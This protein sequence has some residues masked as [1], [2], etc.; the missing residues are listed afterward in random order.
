[1]DRV[2]AIPSRMASNVSRNFMYWYQAHGVLAPWLVCRQPKLASYRGHHASSNA[3]YVGMIAERFTISASARRSKR[4]LGDSPRRHR[5][6]GCNR[7]GGFHLCSIR[8]GARIPKLDRLLARDRGWR[9][10]FLYHRLKGGRNFN[11]SR[12]TFTT[13]GRS[14]AG[15]TVW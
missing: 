9:C 12:P 6:L 5:V 14:V 4:N 10:E 3:W 15:A 2:A 13:R 8:M 11:R 1:M 7:S